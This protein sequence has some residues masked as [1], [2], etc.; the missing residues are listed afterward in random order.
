MVLLLFITTFTYA[1]NADFC[2][3]PPHTLP[4]PPGVYSKS[5]DPTYLNNFQSK[6]FNI[7]FWGINMDDGSYTSP[8]WLITLEKVRHSVDLL[9]EQYASMNICFNL[10]GMDTI[11]S[12]TH[13][14]GSYLGAIISYAEANGY[15]RQ[16]AINVYSPHS[17]SGGGSGQSYYNQ[18]KLAI[19]SG[20]IG[21]NSRTLSHE[22]GHCFGLIHTFDD[23][24]YKID[25]TNCEHVTGDNAGEEGVGDEVADTSAVPNFQ[26]EQTN[27]FAYAVHEAGLVSSWWD[28]RA[29]SLRANGFG[30][31]F[32]APVIAQAL[33]DYGFTLSEIN[34]L[35]YNPAKLDAYSDILN[36]KYAPDSR[37]ND[38]N[39]PFFK[40]C[41]GTPYQVTLAD[42]RNIMA[43]SF[44]IC[45][46]FFTTGQ[47]IRVHETIEE[48]ASKF[49]PVMS[50]YSIDLYVRDTESDIGQ[51][52]NIHAYTF[53]NSKDIWVR[54]QNDGTLIQEHQNPKYLLQILIMYI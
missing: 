50:Q 29:L 13:H 23:D 48:Y 21:S 49:V 20:L 9:N 28:G 37:I 17:L 24:N 42:Y 6:S 51:E 43:Y 52:P 18:T 15:M 41:Q 33:A 45:G 19:N 4:N 40:D 54:N 14:A 22:V 7:F 32:I 1:Q 35:R 12:T 25:Q 39:S 16:D 8:G 30:S 10:V 2:A 31:L 11:N 34:Y 46:E 3:T 53:W 44:P 47:G 5:I 27:H 26:R 38:L 36:C